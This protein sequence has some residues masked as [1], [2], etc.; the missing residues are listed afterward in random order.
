MFPNESDYNV[1]DYD[2]DSFFNSVPE[3]NPLV[4]P[5]TVELAMK[6]AEAFENPITAGLNLLLG[7]AQRSAA[8]AENMRKLFQEWVEAEEQRLRP[9]GFSIKRIKYRPTDHG[10][11]NGVMVL[12]VSEINRKSVEFFSLVTVIAGAGDGSPNAA[13]IYGGFGRS[14]ISPAANTMPE[15]FDFVINVGGKLESHNVRQGLEAISLWSK[16]PFDGILYSTHGSKDE[17]P[18]L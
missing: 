8:E 18:K 2:R 12:D 1:P 13:V 11:T 3:G 4:R 17:L 16:T 6:G 9:V 5:E 10:A 7:Y 14:L 15:N